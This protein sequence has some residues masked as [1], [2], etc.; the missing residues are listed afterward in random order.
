MAYELAETAAVTAEGTIGE[1]AVAINER[2][3]NLATFAN[4]HSQNAAN[5]AAS[6]EAL[7]LINALYDYVSEAKTYADS[8]N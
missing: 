8:K 1:D 3:F 5:S 6:A 4:Y 7:D 2:S